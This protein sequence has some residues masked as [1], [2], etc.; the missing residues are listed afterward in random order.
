MW[1]VVFL[2]QSDCRILW[3]SVSLGKIAHWLRFFVDG[4]SDQVK[5][6][7]ERSSFGRM[8][9]VV[10][11]I[12]SDRNILWSSISVER[13]KW[14][15]LLCLFFAFLLFVFCFAL[16]FF[17][18][19]SHQRKVAPETTKFWLLVVCCVSYLIRLKASLIRD[20]TGKNH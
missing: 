10:P 6:A 8:W 20:K 19:D 2:V 16:L 18:G 3:S 17:C 12:Q 1:S 4:D 14:Y 5:V 13:I 9:L 15:L 11:L 7:C